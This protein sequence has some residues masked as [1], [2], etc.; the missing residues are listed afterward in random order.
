MVKAVVEVHLSIL[1]FVEREE[2]TGALYVFQDGL[3]ATG[4]SEN[5]S[6]L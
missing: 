2:A 4:V 3:K 6:L 5:L 1:A